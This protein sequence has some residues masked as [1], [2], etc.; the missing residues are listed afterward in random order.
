MVSFRHKQKLEKCQIIFETHKVVQNTCSSIT[1]LKKNFDKN[2]KNIVVFVIVFII[3]VNNCN[4]LILL[5]VYYKKNTKLSL[6]ANEIHN[7]NNIFLR[8]EI[9]SV[10]KDPYLK[11]TYCLSFPIFQVDTSN[12]YKIYKKMT[13]FVF[14]LILFT[15]IVLSFLNNDCLRRNDIKKEKIAA[16]DDVAV[17]LCSS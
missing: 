14:F 8:F 16:I 12:P 6:G 13:F 9:K 1:A 11:E 3:C 4:F 10:T 5:I 15:I 17:E 2:E 7:K